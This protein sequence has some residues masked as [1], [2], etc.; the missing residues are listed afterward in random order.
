MK[1]LLLFAFLL[2]TSWL[3]A[4]SNELSGKWVG[5]LTQQ[6]GGFRQKYY[7]EL[8]IQQK[9]NKITGT[10][11]VSVEKVHA[12][13]AFTGEVNGNV[14]TFKENRIIQYSKLEDMAWCLKWGNLSLRKKGSTWFLEGMWDG[15]SIYGPCIPGKVFLQKEVPRA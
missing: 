3:A 11:Y 7:C 2:F 6:E 13:M 9:G 1:N 10:T 15:Q 5:V 12:E 14:I 8:V 4:Q